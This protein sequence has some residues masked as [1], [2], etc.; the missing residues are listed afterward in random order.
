LTGSR[1]RPE[2]EPVPE[3]GGAGRT[4]QQGT[5]S[6][7]ANGAGGIEAQRERIYEVKRGEKH[8]SKEFATGVS[9]PLR[10]KRKGGGSKNGRPGTVGG[11]RSSPRKAPA[12]GGS[13]RR[14]KSILIPELRLKKERE[15][16]VKRTRERETPSAN[17]FFQKNS[18]AKP[19]PRSRR[20]EELDCGIKPPSITLTRGPQ[21]HPQ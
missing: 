11:H 17:F 1:F 16:P 2:G 6:G 18:W 3:V 4:N 5:E 15:R 20:E 10:R 14:K 8:R 19:T 7:T 12:R 13:P 21:R 9:E